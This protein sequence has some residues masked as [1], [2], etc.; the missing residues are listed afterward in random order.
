[1]LLFVILTNVIY[2]TELDESGEFKSDYYNSNYLKIAKEKLEK[3]DN[4]SKIGIK[5]DIIKYE[6]YEKYGPYSWQ[7]YIVNNKMEDIIDTYVKSN[8]NLD[9]EY[10]LFSSIT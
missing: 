9:E 4:K 7:A 10:F 8:F 2:K 1:M 5:K 3:S 6:L